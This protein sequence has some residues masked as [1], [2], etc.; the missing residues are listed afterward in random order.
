VIRNSTFS[1]NF[2]VGGRAN[3]GHTGAG[4]GGAIF[5]F[6]GSTTVLNVTITNNESTGS[7]EGVY[8]GQRTYEHFPAAFFLH[9]TIIAGNGTGDGRLKQCTMEISTIVGAFSGNLIQGNDPDDPCDN[10]QYP[11]VVSTADP[12][13]SPLQFNQRGIPT[14]AIRRTSPAFNSADPATSLLTDQRGQPRPAMGRYDIGAFEL[15]LDRLAMPCLIIAERTDRPRISM[16]TA[17]APLGYGTMTPAPGTHDF[18]GHTL[19]T[20]TATP[21]PGYYFINWSGDVTDPSNPITTVI[22]QPQNI[23]ANF[24]EYV[25]TSLG[26]AELWIGQPIGNELPMDLVAEVRVN[27]IVVG[28]GQVT[29]AQPVPGSGNSFETATEYV[30]LYSIPLTASAPVSAPADLEI[31]LSARLSCSVGSTVNSGIADLYIG[32][33]LDYGTGFYATLSGAPPATRK[34]FPQY[35][36]PTLSTTPQLFPSPRPHIA[37]PL[38]IMSPRCPSRPYT[39]WGRWSTTIH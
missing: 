36:D 33:Y 30:H 21:N 1:D 15:C 24:G 18:V 23:T 9:N 12:E 29:N 34:Y 5:S 7:G 8:I 16:M 27:S 22:T 14:M 26:S 11:G 4:R 28:T 25:L 17:T 31:L 38:S 32:G 2:A 20:I 19:I 6:H 35:P 13:L 39:L 3:G 37:V 10:P